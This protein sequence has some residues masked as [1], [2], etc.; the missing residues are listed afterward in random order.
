ME[1]LADVKQ[2]LMINS[3]DKDN[4]LN[5][6]LSNTKRA[7][8]FKL[9]LGT[10][11]EIPE[12]LSFIVVE[13]AIKRFNRLRNEGMASYSQE[14]ESITFASNDF[15]D[16]KDDIAQWRKDNGKE[17][18]SLGTAYLLNPLGGSNEV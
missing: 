4:L 16:F 15:D 9:G 18:K 13:V 11:E 1:Y 7:L 12:Q 6:I 8:T 10:G 5:V 17:D 2:L 14:G 3:S